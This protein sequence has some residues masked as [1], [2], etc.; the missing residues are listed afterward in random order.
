MDPQKLVY[1]LVTRLFLCWGPPAAA[2]PRTHE[3]IQTHFP[4]AEQKEMG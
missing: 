2:L 4:H 3:P 1:S